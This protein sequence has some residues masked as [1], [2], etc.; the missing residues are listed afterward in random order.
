MITHEVLRGL[1]GHGAEPEQFSATG[2]GTH[3]EGFVVQVTPPHGGSWIGNFQRG[4]KRFDSVIDLP[5]EKRLI[6]VAGGVAYVIDAVERVCVRHFGSQIEQAWSTQDAVVFSNGI[7][8]EAVGAAGEM[9]WRSRRVSW[10]GLRNLKMAG[11]TITGEAW[12]PADEWVPF[13][14][15][16]STGKAQGG[17]YPEN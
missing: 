16:L 2:R 9:L 6:V 1:P 17:A 11:T 15:D 4:L 14:L 12:R 8:F 7:D 10:D 3:R 5:D 13:L